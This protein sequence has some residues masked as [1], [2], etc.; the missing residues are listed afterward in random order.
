MLPTEITAIVP[1][2]DFRPLELGF[3][4]KYIF[5]HL[6]TPLAKAAKGLRE[7]FEM[8][9][10]N[11]HVNVQLSA[12]MNADGVGEQY[13]AYFTHDVPQTTLLEAGVQQTAAADNDAS[14]Y[15]TKNMLLDAFN[16]FTHTHRSAQLVSQDGAESIQFVSLATKLRGW[17]N[18]IDGS[19]CKIACNTDIDANEP[20]FHMSFEYPEKNGLITVTL[21]AK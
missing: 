1:A 9:Q 21:Y 19:A 6:E 16:E 2:F 15:V 7:V 5:S 14:I 18:V 13:V 12:A 8:V 10:M 4:Q 11:P 3:Y 17:L 20:S